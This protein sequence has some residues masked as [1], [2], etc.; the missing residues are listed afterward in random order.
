M[1]KQVEQNIQVLLDNMNIYYQQE[2]NNYNKRID[3]ILEEIDSIE[4]IS[5]KEDL[6]TISIVVSETRLLITNVLNDSMIVALKKVQHSLDIIQCLDNMG[7][8]IYTLNSLKRNIVNYK[9]KLEDFFCGRII[10]AN[11]NLKIDDFASKIFNTIQ[12][13]K[14]GID[15]TDPIQK[16]YIEHLNGVNDISSIENEYKTFLSG[17]RH[18]VKSKHIFKDGLPLIDNPVTRLLQLV[19]FSRTKVIS[20]KC[21]CESDYIFLKAYFG[22]INDLE[23]IDTISKLHSITFTPTMYPTL[24]IALNDNP[25]IQH[26]FEYEIFAISNYFS[27]FD[28]NDLLFNSTS[29]LKTPS[30]TN[31]ID[32]SSE[33]A[34]LPS[35][36]ISID[37]IYT[38]INRRYSF[39]DIF[40]DVKPYNIYENSPAKIMFDMSNLYFHKNIKS[41]THINIMTNKDDTLSYKRFETLFQ[42]TVD[43][44]NNRQNINN[45]KFT[46]HIEK[47]LSFL[48]IF[49]SIYKHTELC[50]D[51]LLILIDKND[52][53]FTTGINQSYKNKNYKTIVER[54]LVVRLDTS[55]K[56]D[57]INKLVDSSKYNEAA[58]LS[59]ELVFDEIEATYYKEPTIIKFDELPPVSHKIAELL[60]SV[61]NDEYKETINLLIASNE[62]YWSI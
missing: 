6:Y 60:N 48:L 5:R 8:L 25:S 3:H 26:I 36:L 56:I 41:A 16:N 29:S 44:I 55:K 49:D 9:K 19:H 14:C 54:S 53:S 30:K 62:N 1:D 7:K 59:K 23:N 27:D 38:E 45:A 22:S 52:L 20:N 10:I 57:K 21:I 17:F 31:F 32:F 12:K 39:Y 50:E 61:N 35:K 15:V 46:R 28:I 24:L 43:F 34:S 18:F 11:D 47:F 58:A 51:S 33:I 4:S 40:I 42:K 13:C 37:K 2:L